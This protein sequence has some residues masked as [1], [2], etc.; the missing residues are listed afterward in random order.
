MA[1]W[2][3]IAASN[4]LRASWPP[5]RVRAGRVE[6]DHVERLALEK[7]ARR[8]LRCVGELPAG[9]VHPDRV[10]RGVEDGAARRAGDGLVEPLAVGNV[11]DDVPRSG[12]TTVFPRTFGRGS[13]DLAR[14]A[15]DQVRDP[16]GDVG[17]MNSLEY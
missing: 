12:S 13:N 6:C 9:E 3:A 11:A 2:S 15:V 16:R 5:G 8:G 1:W 14:G 7:P 17:G 4:A 10:P